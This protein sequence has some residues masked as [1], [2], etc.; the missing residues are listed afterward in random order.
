MTFNNYALV[1]LNIL[2]QLHD[3]IVVECY[4]DFILF[5]LLST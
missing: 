3:Y 5:Y 2:S 1:Y 4:D